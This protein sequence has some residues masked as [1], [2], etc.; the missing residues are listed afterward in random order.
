MA[1]EE[2]LKEVFRYSKE[3]LKLDVEFNDS[4]KEKISKT[5]DE[6]CMDKNISEHQVL[7]DLIERKVRDRF[8]WD[9]NKA[10]IIEYAKFY[11]VTLGEDFYNED[12]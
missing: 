9:I 6:R 11:N 3:F 5:I 1:S 2:I 8:S 10:I 12:I 4:W 7:F